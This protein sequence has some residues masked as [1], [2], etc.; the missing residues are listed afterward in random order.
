MSKSEST[1]EKSEIDDSIADLDTPLHKIFGT[2]GYDWDYI[3]LSGVEHSFTFEN[4]FVQLG[5]VSSPDSQSPIVKLTHSDS[6]LGI[7]LEWGHINGSREYVKTNIEIDTGL[8]RVLSDAL[9]QAAD[10]A[11]ETQPK[12]A[13]NSNQPAFLD[14]ILLETGE[15]DQQESATDMQ[16]GGVERVGEFTQESP[17]SHSDQG[18]EF[19]TG[20]SDQIFLGSESFSLTDEHGEAVV[21]VCAFGDEVVIYT[22]RESDSSTFHSR[23]SLSPEASRSLASRLDTLIEAIRYRQQKQTS[24]DI[25][26]LEGVFDRTFDL[27]HPIV[28]IL[29]MVGVMVFL[30]VAMAVL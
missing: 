9:T 10:I 17:Q 3:V 1:I 11:E 14:D 25:D 19:R 22:T 28:T 26:E 6:P 13:P 12:K 2:D 15:D 4:H 21:G 30:G 23:I 20:A 29:G 7:G 8:G 24:Q 16:C 18:V 27:T 5:E